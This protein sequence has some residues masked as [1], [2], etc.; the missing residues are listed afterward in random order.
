MHTFRFNI[1]HGTPAAELFRE[2]HGE[3]IAAVKRYL[4]PL[5]VTANVDDNLLNIALKERDIIPIQDFA[6]IMISVTPL[7]IFSLQAQE[8][9]HPAWYLARSKPHTHLLA[10]L[11]DAQE[12]VGGPRRQPGQD[13][14]DQPTRA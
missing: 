2:R 7:P 13:L 5:L 3:V 12:Q 11:Q 9:D 6:K 10:G 4:D 8:R 1:L 14:P